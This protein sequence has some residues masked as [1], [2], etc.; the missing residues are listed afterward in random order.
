MKRKLRTSTQILEFTIE[1]VWFISASKSPTFVETE[2]KSTMNDL[3]QQSM[4]ALCNGELIDQM[5]EL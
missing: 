4:G 3:V 2:S 1:I 5:F